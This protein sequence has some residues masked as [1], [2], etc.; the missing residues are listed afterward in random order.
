MSFLRFTR[1]TDTSQIPERITIWT[2]RA[3]LIKAGASESAFDAVN[4]KLARQGYIARGG[5][6]I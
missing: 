4:R 5:Q 6:I 2:F 3:H 1:L